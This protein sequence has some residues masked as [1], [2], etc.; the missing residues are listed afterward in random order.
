LQLLFWIT[1]FYA[2]QYPSPALDFS[3]F[4]VSSLHEP[5]QI[6]WQTL[7]NNVYLNIYGHFVLDIYDMCMFQCDQI[8]RLAQ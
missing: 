4:A 1:L 6:D 2:Y 5:T 3:I 8:S 7:R